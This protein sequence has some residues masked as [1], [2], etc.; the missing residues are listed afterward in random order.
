MTGGGV[1]S[2]VRASSV[3]RAIRVIGDRWAILVIRDAFQGIRRFDQF[4]ERSG[5]SRSTLTRRLHSLVAAGILQR[6]QYSSTPAR[7]D[8]RLTPKG[9]DLFPL[10]IWAWNWERRWA[11]RGAGIPLR[12]RHD[13]GHAMRAE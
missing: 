4:V 9:R 6:V 11:P 10:S 2:K 3:T 7:W 13:C 5:A 12:L 8:Y 1:S